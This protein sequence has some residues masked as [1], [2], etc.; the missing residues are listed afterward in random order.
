[1]PTDASKACTLPDAWILR[2]MQNSSYM[3]EEQTSQPTA[4]RS[5]RNTSWWF[6]KIQMPR[7]KCLCYTC[8]MWTQ[9]TRVSALV[10]RRQTKATRAPPCNNE[11]LALRN[12]ASTMPNQFISVSGRKDVV[13]KD[14]SACASE[15]NLW[16][17]AIVHSSR[18]HEYLNHLVGSSTGFKS[19]GKRRKSHRLHSICW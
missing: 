4:L 12:R 2:T 11:L 18:C 19:K 1:M 7:P 3:V 13:P 5:E 6:H 8:W 16:I 15:D 14:G 17:K 10:C 9:Q